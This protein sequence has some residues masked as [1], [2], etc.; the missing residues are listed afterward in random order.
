MVVKRDRTTGRTKYIIYA[1]EDIFAEEGEL[2]ETTVGGCIGLSFYSK[3]HRIACMAHFMLPAV[4]TSVD[5][6]SGRN[7]SSLYG[8]N[9]VRRLTDGI[10]K[11]GLDP[12][13]FT[14]S[15]FG[16]ADFVSRDSGSGNIT[17]AR[18]LV[19]AEDISIIR[20]DVGGN[21]I[22]KVVFD[23]SDGRMFIQQREKMRLG[24]S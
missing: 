19:E 10:R 1:G 15:I 11:R 18:V 14:A 13:C 12:T 17:L 5:S 16:G 3:D 20:E 9:A 4:R 21:M 22:R 8:V 23:S 6:D 24:A 2:I 7:K